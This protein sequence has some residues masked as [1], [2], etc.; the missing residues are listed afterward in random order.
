LEIAV[1]PAILG[2]LLIRSGSLY[3]DGSLRGQLERLR[4]QLV[5]V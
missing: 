5:A 3:Y 4:R 1:D 2:G